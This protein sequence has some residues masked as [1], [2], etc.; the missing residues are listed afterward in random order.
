MAKRGP[1]PKAGKKTRKPKP[2]PP[3]DVVSTEEAA[4]DMRL[5]PASEELGPIVLPSPEDS[6][7]VLHELAGLYHLR[8]AA[9]KRH[10]D[11]K[12]KTKIA[13]DKV[14]EYDDLIAERIRTATHE[15]DLPL[16]NQDEAEAD[17]SRIQ[18]E[19]TKPPAPLALPEP[20]PASEVPF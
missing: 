18:A 8:H 15:S 9:N 16:F 20:A 10:E 2:A 6:Q 5:T 3:I 4:A 11:L 7:K 13:A 12:S 14:K 1:K 19:A 17:L